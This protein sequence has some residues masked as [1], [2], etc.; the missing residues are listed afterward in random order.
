MQPVQRA[1]PTRPRPADPNWPTGVLRSVVAVQA[2][3]V[4]AQAALVGQFLSGNAAAL[5]WHER[6]AELVQLLSLVQLVAAIVA[7]RRGG[8]AWPVPVSA[9]LVLAVGIQVGAGYNRE[10]AL[11]VPLGVAILGF[12]VWLVAGLRRKRAET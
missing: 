7:W 8:R 6:N 2:L 3:L 9:L 10:L 4:F 1:E 5:E 12:S 11:H